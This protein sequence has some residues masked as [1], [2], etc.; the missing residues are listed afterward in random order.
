[1]VVNLRLD[2]GMLLGRE[3]ADEGRRRRHCS[4]LPVVRCAMTLGV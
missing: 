1:M 4:L 2:R 3:G